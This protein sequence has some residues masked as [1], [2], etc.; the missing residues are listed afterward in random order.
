[1]TP[2]EKKKKTQSVTTQN[3]IEIYTCFV[4]KYDKCFC[5]H[6][7]CI[8]GPFEEVWICPEHQGHVADSAGATSAETTPCDA[9]LLPPDSWSVWTGTPCCPLPV[10]PSDTNFSYYFQFHMQI[11]S[12][13][14]SLCWNKGQ[15]M[16]TSSR[17]GASELS[18]ICASPAT[19]SHAS[20]CSPSGWKKNKQKNNRR[21]V[22]LSTF[23]FISELGETRRKASA[24][25][26]GGCNPTGAG[27]GFNAGQL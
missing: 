26:H 1:M 7:L 10:E 16:A 18:T 22:K 11:W 19:V 14:Q 27:K 12:W 8:C 3:K 9:L 17:L 6:A 2:T 15:I 21:Y 5:A 23:P 13:L 20:S 24:Y 25:P 4:G